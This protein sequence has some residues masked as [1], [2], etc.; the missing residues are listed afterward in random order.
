MEKPWY[1]IKRL[2]ERVRLIDGL[3]GVVLVH[4][5][6]ARFLLCSA[7]VLENHVSGRIEYVAIG[8]EDQAA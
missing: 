8:N 1:V 5:S 4:H 2:C 6:Y 3:R 7:L